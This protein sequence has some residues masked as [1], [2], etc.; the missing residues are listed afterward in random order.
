MD[1][2]FLIGGTPLVIE[3]RLGMRGE[4]LFFQFACREFRVAEGF[5][6]RSRK[7]FAPNGLQCFSGISRACFSGGSR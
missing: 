3:L 6:S 7:Y 5:S 2:S 4:A 1:A